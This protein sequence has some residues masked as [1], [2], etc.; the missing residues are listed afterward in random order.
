MSQVMYIIVNQDLN[1][2]AGQIGTYTAW[3]V[4]DYIHWKLP[5][6][7]DD[8]DNLKI[9]RALDKRISDFKEYGNK[10]IILKAHEKD[11]IELERKGYLTVRARGL[12][13]TY[14]D[15]IVTV[16]LGIYDKNIPKWIQ[17]FKTL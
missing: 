1:M 12:Q 9:Y 14:S 16:N 17:K 13:G 2:N 11:L 6:Y 3:T 7:I 5:A 8:C 4:F 15:N 10:I